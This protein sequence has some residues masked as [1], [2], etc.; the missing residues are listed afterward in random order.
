[1]LLVYFVTTSATLNLHWWKIWQVYPCVNMQ[2]SFMHS[3]QELHRETLQTFGATFICSVLDLWREERKVRNYVLSPAWAYVCMVGFQET[4]Y[5]V[6]CVFTFAEC[7]PSPRRK[8]FSFHNT[9]P[10]DII[11]LLFMK[12]VSQWIV[13]PQFTSFRSVLLFMPPKEGL[14]LHASLF[15]FS[16]F[17]SLHWT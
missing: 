12:W 1:M 5:T 7:S 15:F 11:S 10:R 3:L 4:L 8:V 16:E 14:Y 17:I 6:V 9:D 2:I 13:F